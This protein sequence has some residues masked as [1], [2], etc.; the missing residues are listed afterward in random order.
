MA[1]ENAKKFADA[2]QNTPCAND[3]L[4]VD[5][6]SLNTIPVVQN[7]KK[8]WAIGGGVAGGASIGLGIALAS[9]PV[10][11]IIAGIA[12]VGGAVAYAIAPQS[13]ADM[14]QVMVMDGPYLIK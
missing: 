10:G 2:L 4:A 12:A 13:L 7:G 6:V 14:E 11:W 3:M 8:Q 5:V 1:R 9:N